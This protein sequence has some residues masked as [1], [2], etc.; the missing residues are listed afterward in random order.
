MHLGIQHD[1]ISHNAS[2]NS[3]SY[4]YLII[5]LYSHFISLCTVSVTTVNHRNKF[6][7]DQNYYFGKLTCSDLHG[8]VQ[9]FISP[10]HAFSWERPAYDMSVFVPG[11][12]L[13]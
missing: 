13:R 10:L 11:S 12:V 4:M 5:C 7:Y 6:N 8:E 3:L 2:T 9:I 1:V